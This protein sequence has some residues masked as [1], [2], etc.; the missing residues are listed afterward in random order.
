MSA[1]SSLEARLALLE[2]RLADLEDHR[3]ITQ[4]ITFVGPAADAGLA[5]DFADRWLPE[6]A[7]N[8]GARQFVGRDSVRK[9]VAEGRH[10]EYMEAGCAHLMTPPHIQVDGDVAVATNY[11][12][13][14]IHDAEAGLWE[15]R[16][17]SSNR[18]QLRRTGQ[19]WRVFDRSI[20]VL[21]GSQPARDLLRSVIPAM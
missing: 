8:V 14:A 17:C 15:P 10:L 13:L 19:G 12:V 6:G 3:E 16:R 21:D 11:T 9:V 18:W 4:L 7:Y 20:D 1:D 2:T 5:D